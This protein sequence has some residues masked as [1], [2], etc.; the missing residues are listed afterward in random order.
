MNKAVLIRNLPRLFALVALIIIFGVFRQYGVTFDEPRQQ[1][2]AEMAYHYYETHGQNTEAFSYFN[3]KYYGAAFEVFTVL[4]GKLLPLDTYDVRHLCNGL[5]GLLGCM[6][7]YQIGVLMRARWLG[8]IAAALLFMNPSWFGHM[9]NNS[10]DIPFAAGYMWSLYFLLRILRELPK[11][12]V[13]AIFGLG[14]AYGFTLGVRIGGLVFIGVIGF[15]CLF[16]TV[17]PCSFNLNGERRQKQTFWHSML[18]VAVVL[19]CALT[20]AYVVM[21][22]CWPWAQDAPLLHPIEA[23][24]KMAKFDDWPGT[25]L[26]AGKSVDAVNLPRSYLFHY[27]LIKTPFTYLLGCAVAFFMFIY[28]VFIKRKRL[29]FSVSSLIVLAMSVCIPV[30]ATLVKHSTLYDGLRH[31]LF[32]IPILSIIAAAGYLKLCRGVGY[33]WLRYALLSAGCIAF[34]MQMTTFVKLHP[35]QYVYYNELVGGVAGA[36]HMYE[37]DYWAASYKEGVETLEAIVDADGLETNTSVK[38]YVDG[39]FLSATPYFPASFEL[40]GPG[41][42]AY[43]ITHTRW[44]LDQSMPGKRVA[45]IE[46]C[47][48][49]LTVIHKL[50]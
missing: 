27:F 41:E 3:M 38:I 42:A 49:V 4:C 9:F 35:Y 25:V 12:N 17:L 14:V 19:G 36:Q 8:L 7:V 22:L 15:A 23:I 5:V 13:G 37:M 30:V 40:A 6:A 31:F 46:R 43:G 50:K 33:R 45:Q 44:G 16:A 48:A 10:K 21:L 32:A 29:T 18:Q 11:L 26:F 47:G 2:Y 20:L 28:A 24:Q 39:P 1:D 34:C